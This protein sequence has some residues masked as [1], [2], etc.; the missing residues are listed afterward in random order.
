MPQK[1]LR[2]RVLESWS[3]QTSGHIMKFVTVL[4]FSQHNLR[5]QQTIATLPALIKKP[6]KTHFENITLVHFFSTLNTVSLF[7]Y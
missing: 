2:H 4:L 1:Y 3:P 7:K 6:T 5:W